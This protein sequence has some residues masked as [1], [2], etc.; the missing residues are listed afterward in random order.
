MRHGRFQYVHYHQG[1]PR[2]THVVLSDRAYSTIISEVLANN[3]N[4]TGGVLLGHIVGTVWYVAE[5]IPPGLTSTHAEDFFSWDHE[6]V[7]YL[8]ESISRSYAIPTTILGFWHRHP[9]S[10]DYFSGTDE[11]TIRS[12]LEL[13]NFGLLS[14]LVNVDPKLRMTFYYA[15]GNQLMPVPYDHGNAYFPEELLQHATPERLIARHCG[16]VQALQMKDSRHLDPQILPR[17]VSLPPINDL[18]TCNGARWLQRPG[19]EGLADTMTGLM[20]RLLQA[21]ANSS[22]A[23]IQGASGTGVTT[24]ANNIHQLYTDARIISPDRVSRPDWQQLKAQME[25][26]PLGAAD[27][28]LRRASGGLLIIDD[29][30]QLLTHKAG[31]SMITR[32]LSMQRGYGCHL[33]LCGRTTLHRLLSH[34]CPYYRPDAVHTIEP[35]SAGV[36]SLILVQYLKRKGLSLAPELTE[37]VVSDGQQVMRLQQLMGLVR[38]HPDFRSGLT[39]A[40]IARSTELHAEDGVVT[41]RSLPMDEYQQPAAEPAAAES[42]PEEAPAEAAQEAATHSEPETP[43]QPA[44]EAAAPDPVREAPRYEYPYPNGYPEEAA[45]EPDDPDRPETWRQMDAV[46]S[47]YEEL[48][49]CDYGHRSALTAFLRHLN[50]AHEPV[51]LLLSGQKG[52]GRHTLAEAAA[53]LRA[54]LLEQPLRQAI[55]AR[56]SNAAIWPGVCATAREKQAMLLVEDLEGLSESDVDRCLECLTDVS[57]AVIVNSAETAEKLQPRFVEMGAACLSIALPEMNADELRQAFQILLERSGMT[58]EEEAARLL[59]PVLNACSPATPGVLSDVMKV[60]TLHHSERCFRDLIP[61]GTVERR[62]VL[63]CDAEA[64]VRSLLRSDE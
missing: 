46:C 25:H 62:T 3:R 32:L 6:F 11:D 35:F 33:V 27:M 59:E 31:C 54:C 8:A 40:R 50:Q 64:V 14:M 28:L 42:T 45:D 13:C 12:N 41:L 43:E 4:E 57:A 63:P 15:S 23:L 55:P 17:H 36:M 22:L 1:H 2:C 10:M 19:W 16:T 34:S 37:T 38:K 53:E 9:G 51:V 30:H 18:R 7:N 5:V 26:N 20:G 56:A 47:A 39:M 60:L 44:Q 29:A 52:S 24:I 21:R 48:Y 58:I 49:L 61:Y